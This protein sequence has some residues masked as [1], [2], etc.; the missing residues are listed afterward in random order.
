MTESPQASPAYAR[1]PTDELSSTLWGS[2]TE[3]EHG[4]EAPFETR[5]LCLLVALAARSGAELPPEYGALLVAAFAELGLSP[6]AS[7]DDLDA[8]ISTAISDR[9]ID[10][11]LVGVFED[12][13]QGPL[14]T[15]AQEGRQRRGSA[16]I[17][18]AEGV[19]RAPG[20]QDKPQ[21][22]ARRLMQQQSR[23]KN[24]IR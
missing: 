1:P 22:T 3:G 7:P 11:R 6:E 5:D 18:R 8:A 17:G 14:A 21:L 19:A 23:G 4:G 2:L 12:F 10:P 15:A 20:V 24:I 13:R 9:P 16:L